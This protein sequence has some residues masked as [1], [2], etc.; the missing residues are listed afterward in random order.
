MERKL[1]I[2]AARRNV[3]ESSS[4]VQKRLYRILRLP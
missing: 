2:P 4:N 3:Q 1:S